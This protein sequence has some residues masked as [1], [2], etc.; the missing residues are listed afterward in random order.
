MGMDNFTNWKQG[1]FSVFWTPCT[2]TPCTQLFTNTFLQK[3]LL[4]R[5]HPTVRQD[6]LPAMHRAFMRP[7]LQRIRQKTERWHQAACRW[8]RLQ[9]YLSDFY[10][11]YY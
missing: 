8:L 4:T 11:I 10:Q 5:H 7:S 2:R 1:N 3:A 6:V 9:N